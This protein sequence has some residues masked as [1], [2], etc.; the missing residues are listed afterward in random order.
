MFKKNNFNWNLVFIILGGLMLIGL[1]LLV[2][3]SPELIWSQGEDGLVDPTENIAGVSD[4]TQMGIPDTG[5]TSQYSL[6]FGE[7]LSTPS[8]SQTIESSPTL[9]ETPT[10]TITPTVTVFATYSSKPTSTNTPRPAPTRI[11]PTSTPLPEQGFDPKLC[12]VEPEQTAHPHYCT[13]TP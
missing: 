3:F 2:I 7:L 8:P 10:S 11:P 9:T 1:G 6:G 5:G 13:P 4:S 12:K